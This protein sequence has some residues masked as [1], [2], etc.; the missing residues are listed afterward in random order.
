MVRPLRYTRFPVSFSIS[1]F[2]A[3]C[4]KF[5]PNSFTWFLFLFWNVTPAEIFES[6]LVESIQLGRGCLCD[7]REAKVP[8]C[9]RFRVLNKQLGV[10]EEPEPRK[11][12]DV[13]LHPTHHQHRHRW[14][15]GK[16]NERCHS[17]VQVRAD[18]T[19]VEV[20]LWWTQEVSSVKIMPSQCPVPSSEPHIRKRNNMWPSLWKGE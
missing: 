17:I 1:L 20:L 15:L 11:N 16:R 4:I 13:L 6:L 19:G 3:V 7:N 5:L 18:V 8:H 12:L 2:L 9:R 10:E 14:R